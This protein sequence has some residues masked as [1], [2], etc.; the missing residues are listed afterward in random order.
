[1]ENGDRI[2]I[3]EDIATLKAHVETIMNNHL[4]HLY[5]RV[6]WSLGIMVGGMVS[7]ILLLLGI[8]FNR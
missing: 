8:L 5:N 1:M 7:I 2:K 6:N 4:P 3:H